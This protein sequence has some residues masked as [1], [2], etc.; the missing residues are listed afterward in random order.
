M[1]RNGH[2][3]PASFIVKRVARLIDRRVEET[4]RDIQAMNQLCA[5]LN[6]GRDEWK[7]S[8]QL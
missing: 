3:D 5:F 4:F 1:D 8:L 7:T 2:V 6:I